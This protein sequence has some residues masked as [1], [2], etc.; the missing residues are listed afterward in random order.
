MHVS[1]YAGDAL[2]SSHHVSQGI[3]RRGFLAGAGVAAAAGAFVG[4]GIAAHADV[5]PAIYAKAEAAGFPKPK[6]IETNG[7]KMA[8]YEKGSGYPVV[9]SHGFPELAFSWRHQIDALAKAGFR[10]I[11][12][13]QRGYGRTDRPEPIEA[14]TIQN[15]T[16]DLAG[17]LDKLGIDKAVF[18]GHD[19]GGLVVWQMAHLHPDRVAGVIGVNTPY[20][21]RSPVPP[22]QMMKQMRGEN[23]YIVYFQKPGEADKF[24]ADNVEKTFRAFLRKS[25]MTAEQFNA[26]PADS[27]ARNFDMKMMIEAGA[28][29]TGGYVCSEEELQYYI[30]TFRET[31]FS[32]GINWY[33]NLDRNWETTAGQPQKLDVPSLYVGAEDDVVLPPSMAEATRPLL[34]DNEMHVIEN[35][36]HW[37]QQDKPE[38][39]N[40]LLI[41]WLTKR[42]RSA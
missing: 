33:R 13:D 2:M 10:A 19:W 42:F 7:I 31:G 4:L 18:C 17:M 34:G 22:I 12:P 21:P 30:E 27:P 37:T 15:L 11:A 26:L 28:A 36:G 35:C 32:G 8:V 1:L 23:N 6:F 40:T 24:L 9:F 3:T 38:E 39:L 20:I 5:D 16:G 25:T 14:Y 29:A 41:G